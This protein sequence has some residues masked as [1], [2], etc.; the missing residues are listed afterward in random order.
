MPPD[1]VL[2]DLQLAIMR[3]VWD[4]GRVTVSEI[5]DAL[6]A[7]RG[8]AQTTVATILSRLE[9]RGVVGHDVSA[10]QFIYFPKVSEPEA[11]RSMVSDLTERLFGGDPA[12]LVSHL[13][14][15]KEFSR[16]DI[17]K[18]KAMIA[19]YEKPGRKDGRRR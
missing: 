5:T 3:V 9:K 19:E 16:G 8:L 4:R 2:T 13:I 15:A 10:R 12:A 14:T 18:L 11:R 17:A 1:I 6:R 7:D